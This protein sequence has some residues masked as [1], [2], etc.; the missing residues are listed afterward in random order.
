[1]KKKFIIVDINRKKKSCSIAKYGIESN[2]EVLSLSA[3]SSYLLDASLIEYKT[4]HDYVLEEKYLSQILSLYEE[5]LCLFENSPSFCFLFYELS[6]LMTKFKYFE[7]LRSIITEYK[8][9]GCEVCLFSDAKNNNS[10][11]NNDSFFSSLFD[12]CIFIGEDDSFFYGK[13]KIKSINSLIG[14][15]NINK[16]FTKLI[17]PHD[18]EHYKYGNLNIKENIKKSGVFKYK[19]NEDMFTLK[20]HELTAQYE[21]L[22]LQA[23]KIFGSNDTYGSIYHD[24]VSI[25]SKAVPEKIKFEN[26]SIYPFTYIHKEIDYQ[27]ILRHKVKGLPVVISQHGSYV[28]DKSLQL[29]FSEIFPADINLVCNKYTK[30]YF[31]NQGAK[32][33]HIVGN[34]LFDSGVE[35]KKIK[36]DYLYLVYCSGYSSDAGCVLGLEYVSPQ[37]YSDVFK[38]HQSVIKLFG[39]KYSNKTLC[40]KIKSSIVLGGAYVPFIELAK[41]YKNIHIEFIKPIEKLISES[42][43]VISDYYSSNFISRDI[44]IKK[45]VILFNATPYSIPNNIKTDFEKMFTIIDGVSE[46]DYVVSNID[47]VSNSRVRDIKIIEKYSSPIVSE[48]MLNDALKSAYSDFFNSND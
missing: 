21:N 39:E 41:K 35:E 24:V 12:S 19:I 20:Y 46:L 28:D 2:C 47:D 32:S 44:H 40:I 11:L 14:Y 22:M 29:T 7:C 18:F 23:E 30:E 25:I 33:V 5:V 8:D 16:F 10:Y 36:Y 17:A 3:Y 38:R 27:E 26:N 4:F 13:N 37:N 43:R 34:I 42:D 45:D 48:S 6:L 9:K 15:K 31:E 1:M